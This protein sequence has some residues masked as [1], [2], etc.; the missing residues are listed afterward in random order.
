VLFQKLADQ[1]LHAVAWEIAARQ[2]RLAGPARLGGGREVR[3]ELLQG[4]LG[5]PTIG[6][7]LAPLWGRCANT[8]RWVA[9]GNRTFT[10]YA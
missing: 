10:R 5:Q 9:A 2:R 7:D 1:D 4:R 8:G 6:G 3:A